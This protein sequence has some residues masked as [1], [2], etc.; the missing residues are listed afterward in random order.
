MGVDVTNTDFVEGNSPVI[1]TAPNCEVKDAD[2]TTLNFCSAVVTNILNPGNEFLAVAS[3]GSLSGSY[4]SGTGVLT[5]GGPADL[6][7]FTTLLRS[8]TY[9]NR[10]NVPDVSARRLVTVVCQD[11]AGLDSP[12]AQSWVTVR[13]SPDPPIVDL[14]PGG[15]SSPHFSAVFT[16]GGSAVSISAATA[17]IVDPD[18]SDLS[19]CVA[20][21]KNN[22]DGSAESLEVDTS[23]LAISASFS[24]DVLTMTGTSVGSVAPIEDFVTAIRRIVYDNTEV[25]P[26]TTPRNIDIVCSDESSQPSTPTTSTVTIA[27]VN[28]APEVLVGTHTVAYQEGDGAVGVTPTGI[29]ITDVDSYNLENC[30]AVLQ[31]VPDGS[32]ES[33]SV[34]S[35]LGLNSVYDASTGRLIVVG[36]G[37]TPQPIAHY[38]QVLDTLV[39]SNADEGK[40]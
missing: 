29:S 32:L 3:V 12:V 33:I 22:L 1:I 35:G 20:T 36:P 6:T 37:A 2:S 16:E 10:D 21:L 30:V 24:A 11:D 15:A 39:Y 28:N 23:G 9:E 25:N 5:M 8:L 34:Q 27:P 18:S 17:T 7:Q 13:E 19:A 14:S 4:D 26:S 40:S 38:I 31:P